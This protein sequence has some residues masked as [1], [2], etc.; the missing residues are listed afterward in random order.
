MRKEL[1]FV[2]IFFV[3]VLCVSF[4]FIPHIENDE[5]VYRTLAKR[6]TCNDPKCFIFDFKKYNLLESDVLKILVE[7]AYHQKAFFHPPAFIMTLSLSNRLFHEIGLRLV[8]VV[9]FFLII[10]IMYHSLLLLQI[11]KQQIINTLFI[12]AT[13]SL[14]L[15][16]A[17]KL[18]MDLFLGTLLFTSFYFILLFW[19][20]GL[21]RYSFFAG[22][23]L[24]LATFTKYW[25]LASYIP[26][27]YFLFVISPNKQ[28]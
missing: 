27:I 9:S 22:V 10:F 17:S 26:F 5:A 1:V 20:R 6:I 24:F 15:F 25:A 12:T 21:L 3:F 13:S 4:L 23:F 18:W 28:R 16:N 11:K 8:P 19:K 14:L 7:K 2:C